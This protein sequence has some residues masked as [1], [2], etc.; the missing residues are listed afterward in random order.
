VTAA[1][2]DPSAGIVTKASPR[3]VDETIARLTRVLDHSG[4]ATRVGLQ[5]PNTELV[6]FG[7]PAAGTPV[8]LAAPLA[9]LDLPLKLLVWEDRDGAVWVSYTAP[10]YL[11]AVSG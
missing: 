1:A 7:S 4:E 10:S 5:M 11:A 2:R 3:G 8:M 9:A 6:V